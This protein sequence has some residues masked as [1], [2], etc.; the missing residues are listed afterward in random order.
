MT[1][2]DIHSET[3]WEDLKKRTQETEEK[4]GKS[5]VQLLEEREKRVNDAIE[6]R[7]PDRVPVTIQTGVFSARYVAT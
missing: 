6:L 4:Y 5:V 1:E 2:L 7:I 3:F